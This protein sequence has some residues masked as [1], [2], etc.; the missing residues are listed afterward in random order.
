MGCGR[1]A[2]ISLKLFQC[3]SCKSIGSAWVKNEEQARCS[4]CYDREIEQ[5]PEDIT[6]LKCP[7]CGELAAIQAKEGEWQ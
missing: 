3:E 6:S 4:F 2:S 1:D 5:L 7:K